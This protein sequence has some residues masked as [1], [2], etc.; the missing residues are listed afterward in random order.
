YEP[1][2]TRELDK[3]DSVNE[4][5]FAA[6]V[7]IYFPN[8]IYLSEEWTHKNLDKIF[9]CSDLQRWLCVIQGYSYVSHLRTEIYALF[10]KH[11]YFELILDSKYLKDETKSRYIEFA[12]VAYI[13][14]LEKVDKQEGLFAL[15]IKRANYSELETIV[16]FFWTQRD[17]QGINL[18]EIVLSLYPSFVALINPSTN[19]GKRFASRLALWSEFIDEIDKQSKNWLMCIAPYAGYDYNADTL[20][21]NLARLS[22]KYPL[23][24]YKI[25]KKMVSRPCSIFSDKSVKNLFSN[26]INMGEDGERYAKDI[27]DEY[28]KL[29]DSR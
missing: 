27:A 9:D 16:W 5:E 19:E 14:E 29:G 23:D 4:Y 25:W 6:I 3:P 18:R 12:C 10:R 20:I 8:F 1:I 22:D 21:D 7:G 13:Q 11:D 15:L 24:T 17:N 2:F 26:L 28:L